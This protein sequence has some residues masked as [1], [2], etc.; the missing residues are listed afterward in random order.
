MLFGVG[1]RR[2]AELTKVKSLI[3]NLYVKFDLDVPFGQKN[4]NSSFSSSGE[5]DQRS[6][7]LRQFCSLSIHDQWAISTKFR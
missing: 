7:L 2:D 1:K 4:N 3:D 6:D 5:G